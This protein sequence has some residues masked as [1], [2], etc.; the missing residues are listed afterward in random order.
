MVMEGML[1]ELGASRYVIF[2]AVDSI[3]VQ[4]IFFSEMENAVVYKVPDYFIS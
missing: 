3:V 1:S 4:E 2:C